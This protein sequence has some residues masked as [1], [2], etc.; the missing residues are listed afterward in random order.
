MP[1]AYIA[2]I[3]YH[4]P[5]AQLTN[6]QLAADFPEWGAAKIAGKT[7]IHTRH[8]AAVDEMSSDLAVAAANKLFSS[9]VVKPGEIDFVLLCTQT[10]DFALPTSACLVQHRLGIP[11][12]AGALD[13]NLGCSGYIYGLSLAK[14]LVE[15][16]QAKRVLLLT[17]ETYSKLLDPKDKSVRTIFGDGAAATLVSADHDLVDERIG[18]FVFGTDGSGGPNLVCHHGGFRGE[19]AE[20]A[21][22]AALWMNGPEIFNFTLKVVP[23]AVRRLLAQAKMDL[24]QVDQFVFHQ[25]NLYMLEYLRKKMNVPEDKFVVALAD[26]GNTVSSTIPIALKRS[27]GS[28][29]IKSGHTIMLVGFGV[30]Y[31]WG[32]VI[33]RWR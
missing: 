20:A 30:G 2:A 12:T 26:V 27:I 6:D 14:G 24:A 3:E 13:F 8:I 22:H 18:P 5:Q 29:R 1:R 19:T 4:L 25:A 7:G 32:G 10:P 11:T 28:G 31:S 21:G 17:A 23:D 33:V 15:S 9:G 16:G